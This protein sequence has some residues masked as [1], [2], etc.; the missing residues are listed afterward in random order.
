MFD[1]Q[2]ALIRAETGLIAARAT[3]LAETGELISSFGIQIMRPDEGEWDWDADLSGDFSVCP[4]E[5]IGFI[6]VDF[7][8]VFDRVKR[9]QSPEGGCGT[10]ADV[11]SFNAIDIA[12]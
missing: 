1:T 8:D 4:N 10:L 6:E 7:D 11:P 12:R 3:A 5:P 9:S 2:R